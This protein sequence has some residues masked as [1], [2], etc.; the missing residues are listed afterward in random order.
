MGWGRRVDLGCD[1]MS[2]GLFP[3]SEGLC[4]MGSKAF[5]ILSSSAAVAVEFREGRAALVP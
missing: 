2:L 3:M 5:W 4:W 1:C